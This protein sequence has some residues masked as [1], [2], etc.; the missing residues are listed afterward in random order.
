MR[1]IAGAVSALAARCCGREIS[2]SPG[3]LLLLEAGNGLMLLFIAPATPE[4][5]KSGIEGAG[6]AVDDARTVDVDE[7]PIPLDAV[8]PAKAGLAPAAKPLI[9][10]RAAPA[11]TAPA[12][13]KAKAVE[14]T[15]PEITRR[16][17]GSTINSSQSCVQK[18]LEIKHGY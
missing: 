4:R 18:L 17:D 11:A 7:V 6:G 12:R 10:D 14:P 1:A 15:S 16:N 5:M 13:T 2:I 3:S 9:P 8:A